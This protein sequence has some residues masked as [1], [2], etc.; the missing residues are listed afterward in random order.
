VSETQDL[1][2]IEIAR[3]FEVHVLEGRR[4]ADL[5]DLQPSG[6]LSL[7]PGA[8][9][10]VDQETEAFLEAELRVLAGS[11]LQLEGFCPP[12]ELHGIHLVQGLLG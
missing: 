9:F 10:A 4:I 7:L 5:G 1:G 8:P 2:F 12:Q 3:V 11:E 6:E